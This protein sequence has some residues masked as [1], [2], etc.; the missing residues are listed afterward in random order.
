MEG[1]CDHA[2]LEWSCWSGRPGEGS[3]S[4][5]HPRVT[6]ARPDCSGR[7]RGLR[8][9][10]PGGQDPIGHPAGVWCSPQLGPWCQRAYATCLQCRSAQG[11]TCLQT[12]GCL[13]LTSKVRFKIGLPV[14]L[15]APTLNQLPEEGRGSI[16]FLPPLTNSPHTL[17]QLRDGL[18]PTGHGVLSL[19]APN[20]ADTCTLLCSILLKHLSQ[21]LPH[22]L[23]PLLLIFCNDKNHPAS[24][25]GGSGR[26]GIPK[27]IKWGCS[28]SPAYVR[29]GL[30]R[31]KT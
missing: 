23:S 17:V 5:P 15:G 4:T 29:G 22:F 7:R 30:P 25:Q 21:L 12:L 14:L 10:E 3:S 13:G 8:A 19:P 2:H 26:A 6:P 1:S 31:E 27:P 20:P 28:G 11:E 24:R 16:R 18:R 9:R